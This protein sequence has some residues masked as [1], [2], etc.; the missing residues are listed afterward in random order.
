MSLECFITVICFQDWGSICSHVHCSPHVKLIALALWCCTVFSVVIL[1]LDAD[2]I[3]I[4]QHN[5]TVI[6][7]EENMTQNFHPNPQV[8]G[9]CRPSLRYGLTVVCSFGLCVSHAGSDAAIKTFIYY[10]GVGSYS[11]AHSHQGY[12]C[13]CVCE[14]PLHT[15]LL[16]QTSSSVAKFASCF[17]P[18]SLQT[19][20]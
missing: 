10:I 3:W 1:L 2:E 18:H 4:M 5:I 13:M 11:S 17:L 12:L 20:A 6:I 9:G 7:Y 8:A 14:S 15:L 16:P 19:P